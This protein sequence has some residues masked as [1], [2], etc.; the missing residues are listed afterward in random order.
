VVFEDADLIVINKPRWHGLCTRTR[1]ASGSTLVNALLAIAV[2][3]FQGGGHEA[4][5]HCATGSTQDTSGCLVVAKI[6]RGANHGLAKHSKKHTLSAY[7]QRWST[8]SRCND[9][10]LARREGDRFEPGN[11]P[12]SSRRSLARHR[13]AATAGGVFPRG[14]STPVTPRHAPWPAL[15]H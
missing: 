15:D 12:L 7:Y 3:I 13:T 6:R 5:R 1:A 2:M 8:A 4:P 9:P 10:R 11:I 14:A